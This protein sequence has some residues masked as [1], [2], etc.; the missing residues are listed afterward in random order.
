MINIYDFIET[1]KGNG[2]SSDE[3]QTEYYRA[4]EEEKERKLEEYYNDPIV[5]EGWHQQD[6]ID[7]YRRER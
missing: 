3:A 7:M 4:V 6:I 2:L 5:N 1:C